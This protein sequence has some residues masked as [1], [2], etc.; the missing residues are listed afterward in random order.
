MEPQASES[1]LLLP[2]QSYWSCLPDRCRNGICLLW[3]IL[4]TTS[5]TVQ[6]TMPTSGI[7][8][9]GAQF[10]EFSKFRESTEAWIRLN[11][12]VFSA[13]CVCGT[14]VESLSLT[15]EIVGSSP[16][17]FLKSF[18]FCNWIRWIQWK[19]LGKTQISLSTVPTV[20][21]IKKFFQL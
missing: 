19:H 6:W 9:N 8:L 16:A 5:S 11:L 17:I 15:Q 4:L 13:S 20:E 1:S 21:K 14:V 18:Y 7:F 10:Y 2:M 3:T 12:T